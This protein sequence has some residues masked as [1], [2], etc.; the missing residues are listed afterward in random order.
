[1][2]VIGGEH[3][4]GG[5][6]CL[7]AQAAARCGAG[8]ISVAT[9]AAH[10]PALL[11]ARAELMVHGVESA[12]AIATLIDAA[13]VIAVG[14]GL[15]RNPWG[16]QLLAA[17]LA[18]AKPAVFDADALNMIAEYDAAELP[19]ECVLTP[20]PGEA[21]RLLGTTTAAVEAD[22]FAALEALVEKF[23]RVV[24]L[25]GAGTLIAAPGGA[26]HVIEGGNPGM[27]SGGMG[28]VLTGV[29]AALMAQGLPAVDAAVFAAVLH[30]RA[31]DEA[32]HHGGERG[33]LAG[34]LLAPLRRLVDRL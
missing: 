2:L 12:A 26:V 6:A 34:D 9:R 15:G 8:L 1:V 20:H 11:A 10:I 23:N 30:A 22:R 17:A 13:S 3:G 5:A 33:L 24:L 18:C 21:A 14:P 25:K 27:A 16:Q 19:Q 7:C 4:F 28:D 31:A 32:A 29:I